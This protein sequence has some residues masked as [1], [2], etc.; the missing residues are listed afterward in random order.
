M[1]ARNK[2]AKLILLT[3]STSVLLCGCSDKRHD[4]SENPT[5]TTKPETTLLKVEPTPTKTGIDEENLYKGILISDLNGNGSLELVIGEV[6][7]N[8]GMDKMTIEA[9]TLV[10]ERPVLLFSGAYRNRYYLCSDG[11]IANE[12]SSGA[13]NSEYYRYQISDHGDNFEVIEGIRT[14]GTEV[15]GSVVV[16]WYSTTDDDFDSSNDTQ[17]KEQQGVDKI[18]EYQDMHID[19]SLQPF[20]KYK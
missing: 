17:I 14:V 16:N 4:L 13:A 11:R 9:Y 15:D 19:M 10:D 3:L 12:G 1:I 18:K 20:S 6:N 8:D 2:R 7:G 5:P